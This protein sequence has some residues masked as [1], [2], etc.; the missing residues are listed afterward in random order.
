MSFGR[1]S[2]K[3][4]DFLL[5]Q[6][7]NRRIQR[8]RERGDVEQGYLRGTYL[9]ERLRGRIRA[10]AEDQNKPASTSRPNDSKKDDGGYPPDDPPCYS[11]PRQSTW[12]E[13][14]P[15]TEPWYRPTLETLPTR[16][17]KYIT[18]KL[19]ETCQASLALTSHRM[20]E[21]IGRRALKLKPKFRIKLLQHLERD[22]VLPSHI[23]CRSCTKFHLPFLPKY[24]VDWKKTKCPAVDY[25]HQP[26]I[27][28]ATLVETFPVH[29]A[30]STIAA[31][32]RSARHGWDIYPT[33]ILTTPVTYNI[34][35]EWL[36]KVESFLSA[37][38]VDN[39]LVVKKETRLYSGA[40]GPKG[41]DDSRWLKGIFANHEELSDLCE[42]YQWEGEYD[43]MVW[44]EK[45]KGAKRS[46]LHVNCH[47]SDGVS[48]H[49][50]VCPWVPNPLDGI[51]TCDYCFT[52][53]A[54]YR[55]DEAESGRG[56]VVLLSWHDLG[57]GETVGDLQWRAHR[58]SHDQ[59]GKIR[60]EDDAG[61]IFKK[62]I[63]GT[64]SGP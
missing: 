59:P 43:G 4:Q 18:E 28:C 64:H 5:V 57:R 46:Q 38:V 41:L 61:K 9:E 53:F 48:S 1:L 8:I 13:L 31:L 55:Y 45:D 35:D 56:V 51:E 14:L 21:K 2:A 37:K 26:R 22:G 24:W 39:H 30:F 49:L 54:V 36:S 50:P 32:T 62:F 10:E 16:L 33:E 63:S 34:Q 60:R 17:T 42:H 40:K 20:L 52:D 11:P 27:P 15:P 23:L 7:L 19:S 47:H 58:Y 12:L 44:A 6:L 29:F 25:W 3:A